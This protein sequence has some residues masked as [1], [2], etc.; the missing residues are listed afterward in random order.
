MD[1]ITA[2]QTPVCL[3]NGTPSG[4]DLMFCRL[5]EP[6]TEMQRKLITDTVSRLRPQLPMLSPTTRSGCRADRSAGSTSIRRRESYSSP[7]WTTLTEGPA[8]IAAERGSINEYGLNRWFTTNGIRSNGA[9]LPALRQAALLKVSDRK[10]DVATALAEATTT[11]A[12]LGGRVQTLARALIAVKR[13]RFGD[14]VA[15]INN[16]PVGPRP[17]WV[18]DIQRYRHR[19]PRDW[20]PKPWRPGADL[21]SRYLEFKY[22][23]LPVLFDVIGGAQALSDFLH[24]KPDHL[25]TSVRVSRKAMYEA[26]VTLPVNANGVEGFGQFDTYA[27]WGGK[28]ELIYQI[29]VASLKR[30]SELGLLSPNVVWELMPYSFLVDMVVPVGDFL[31]AC[32]A[33][34]GCHFISGWELEYIRGV[35]QQSG[36]TGVVLGPSTYTLEMKAAAY[37]NTFAFERRQ[38][39]DFPSPQMFVKNPMSWSNAGTVAALLRQLL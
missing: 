32:S 4:D 39:M 18:K 27:R 30:A 23:L 25:L 38:L 7:G 13:G 8:F 21:A 15:A 29:E 26:A 28:I 9:E 10:I 22:G 16:T 17:R 20:E 34:L 3:Y 6:F 12:W 24:S 5:S 36:C 33:T 19:P 37:A 14:A 2:S 1:S 35:S 31:E 11:T